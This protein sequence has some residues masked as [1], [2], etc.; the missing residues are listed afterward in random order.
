MEEILAELPEWARVLFYVFVVLGGAGLFLFGKYLPQRADDPKA[1]ELKAA[2][3]DSSAVQQLAAAVEALAIE[4]RLDRADA[5]KARRVAHELVESM[6]ALTAELKEVR[7]EMR[8]QR[9]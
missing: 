7:T 9:R 4:S 8:M 3:V 6:D 1:F 2:M 5:E